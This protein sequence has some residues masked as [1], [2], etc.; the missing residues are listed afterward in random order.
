MG[1]LFC[2]VHRHVL[3]CWITLDLR[4][5]GGPHY[6]QLSGSLRMVLWKM[7]HPEIGMEVYSNLTGFRN[8]NCVFL[9][10]WQDLSLSWVFL[11]FEGFSNLVACKSWLKS[12]SL[13]DSQK[14]ASKSLPSLKLRQYSTCQFGVRREEAKSC[15]WAWLPGN[16]CPFLVAGSVYSYNL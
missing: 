14:P 13:W 9:F 11:G 2:Y 15:F 5:L 4:P 6:S 12:G 16:R 10:G 1:R 3:F 7:I 8:F